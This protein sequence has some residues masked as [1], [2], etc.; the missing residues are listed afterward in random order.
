MPTSPV[1]A[2][3]SS[4]LNYD[5][6]LTI[7][8]PI[9]TVCSPHGS[10]NNPVR[11]QFIW[12]HPSNQNLLVSVSRV[13]KNQYPHMTYETCMTESSITC[14][15]FTYSRHTNWTHIFQNTS[16]GS[17]L[18]HL[19]FH[20]PGICFSQATSEVFFTGFQSS[21]KGPSSV[22]LSLANLSEIT[23]FFPYTLPT[24]FSAYSTLS[25]T[26]IS[27]NHLVYCLPHWLGCEPQLVRK[28]C[29]FCPLFVPQVPDECLGCSRCS[30]NIC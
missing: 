27:V 12:E 14:H 17:I 22:Q 23:I 1:Q 9:P 15:T 11:S 18:E 28:F 24:F 7:H 2:T 25:N 21:L 26:H 8:G 5:N 20:P 19:L 13:H 29:Q 3:N 16:R 4:P 6:A 30:I 10:Q